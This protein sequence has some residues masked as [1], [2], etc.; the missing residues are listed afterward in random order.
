M[1][2]GTVIAGA[3]GVA[4][5]ACGAEV[6][7]V[8]DAGAASV[9]DGGGVDEGTVDGGGVAVP[10]TDVPPAA[11]TEVLAGGVVGVAGG[12]PGGAV[13]GG[14]TGAAPA[15]PD[16]AVAVPL[17]FGDGSIC[18]LSCASVSVSV[19]VAVSPGAGRVSLGSFSAGG[20]S[21]SVAGGFTGMRPMSRADVSNSRLASAA[22]PGAAVTA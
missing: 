20:G 22:A 17:G 9:D 21:S 14:V 4:G 8:C 5:V 15:V 2:V 13:A 19:N 16:G 7:A 18:G 3:A 1:R 12:S 10:P 6:A 11:G